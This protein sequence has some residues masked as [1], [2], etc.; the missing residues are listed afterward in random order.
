MHT[1]KYLLYLGQ[2][3][4]S[5]DSLKMESICHFLTNS[6]KSWTFIHTY[7]KGEAISLFSWE[8]FKGQCERTFWTLES[9]RCPLPSSIIHN[10]YIHTNY[11]V[12]FRVRSRSGLAQIIIFWTGAF[13]SASVRILSSLL[14]YCW[15]ENLIQVWTWCLLVVLQSRTPTKHGMVRKAISMIS[16]VVMWCSS[17]IHAY[18]LHNTNDS[19]HLVED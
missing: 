5:Q 9:I 19:R 6:T 12:V 8:D 4:S 17:K 1:N 14:W 3:L 13:M 18:A 7:S 2:T 15:W 16:H 10:R 11:I